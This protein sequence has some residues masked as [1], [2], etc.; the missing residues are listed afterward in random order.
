MGSKC[1]LCQR[2]NT[3]RRTHAAEH[4]SDDTCGVSNYEQGMPYFVSNLEHCPPFLRDRQFS[5]IG[6]PINASRNSKRHQL[7]ARDGSSDALS[8]P[9]CRNLPTSDVR[10]HCTRTVP[11]RA[12]SIG[13]N[14]LKEKARRHR[15]RKQSSLGKG[16]CE[17]LGDTDGKTSGLRS[18]CRSLSIPRTRSRHGSCRIASRR[19]ICCT[20]SS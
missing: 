11:C 13:H 17:I 19:T 15:L 14:R 3:H 2:Q 16:I 18:G 10:P 5:A 4:T 6:I 9:E 8:D 1:V 20:A 7:V 12:S